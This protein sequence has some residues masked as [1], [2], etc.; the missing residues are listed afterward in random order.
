MI[1]I[2]LTALSVDPAMS[3]ATVL[4]RTVWPVMIGP[5]VCIGGVAAIE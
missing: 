1:M 3:S 2:C 5:T 4:K